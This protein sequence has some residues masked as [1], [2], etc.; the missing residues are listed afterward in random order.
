MYSLPCYLYTVYSTT[1]RRIWEK[2]KLVG[3]VQT[4]M[5]VW[6][7]PLLVPRG[8]CTVHVV[9]SRL[10]WIDPIASVTGIVP[11][12]ESVGITGNTFLLHAMVTER[13]RNNEFTVQNIGK[14]CLF[15]T[16]NK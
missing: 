16:R 4:G 7:L 12:I 14:P 1:V 13:C 5:W 10:I 8:T 11:W 9:R 6:L 15:F 3:V 2:S